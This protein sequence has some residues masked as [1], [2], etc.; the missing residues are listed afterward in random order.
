MKCW[1]AGGIA[2][3]AVAG[4]GGGSKGPQAPVKPA[5]PVQA[6]A[7][8]TGPG[9]MTQQDEKQQPSWRVNWKAGQVV[10][11]EHEKARGEFS[12]VTGDLYSAGKPATKFTADRAKADQTDQTLTLS[13]G[14][15]LN[16][17]D[18]PW[19]M[20][21]DQ[22]RWMDGYKLL[23]VS[24]HVK[25]KGDDVELSNL[26]SLLA[27]SDMRRVGTPNTFRSMI[28]QAMKASA[29]RK[30]ILPAIAMS[31]ANAQQ[32]ATSRIADFT[33]S[34]FDTVSREIAGAEMRFLVEG[35][36][37]FHGIWTKRGLD[38]RARRA[39]GT[40]TPG[41]EKQYELRTATFSGD[42]RAKITNENRT[43]QIQTERFDYSATSGD[44][45]VHIPGK[46]A[47]NQQSSGRDLVATAARGDAVLV[48]LGSKSRAPL[49]ELTLAG[50]VRATVTQNDGDGS[51]SSTIDSDS[52]KLV[53]TG[54]AATITTGGAVTIRTQHSSAKIKQQDVTIT[55]KSGTVRLDSLGSSSKQPL[56]SVDLAGGV[57]ITMKEDTLKDGLI[58]VIGKA[59]S[60]TYVMHSDGRATVT[61]TGD[62]RFDS[63][64]SDFFGFTQCQ[65]ATIELDELGKVQKAQFKGSGHSEINEKPKSKGSK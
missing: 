53:D 52:L 7:V 39:E 9:T 64:T 10:Y 35:N 14:A 22:I 47:V 5:E 36:P 18:H 59:N 62:V 63:D 31:I 17:I 28:E 2:V 56:N 49:K 8:G 32:P 43:T 57:T 60:L 46:V 11:D 55:G 13:G 51:R 50:G 45:H 12:Q 20:N 15:T 26:P 42:V 25:I 54:T 24:G 61:L 40:A 65:I 38:L 4:C 1:I 48:P 19:T 16:S 6:H 34:E 41:E 29:A 37:S 27:T 3:L 21:A 33:I 58:S 30:V 44:G 23:E